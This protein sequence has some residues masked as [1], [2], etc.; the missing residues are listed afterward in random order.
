M[1]PIREP[2]EKVVMAKL[3]R[4]EFS[5]F[6]DICVRKGKSFNFM[7]K[8]LINREITAPFKEHRAGENVFSYERKGDT[9]SWIIKLDDGSEIEI[10]E[11]LPYEYLRDLNFKI[12]KVFKN[13]DEIIARKKSNSVA[14]PGKLVGGVEDE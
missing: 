5:N 7:I 10:L 4:E 1:N 2:E 13:R 3:S 14:I 9:F 12:D 8:E 6:K 11:N